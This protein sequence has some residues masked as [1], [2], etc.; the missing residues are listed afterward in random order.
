MRESDVLLRRANRVDE[1]RRGGE[2]L[3]KRLQVRR[4]VGRVL[5]A[6]SVLLI[7]AGL[8]S[9]LACVFEIFS[10]PLLV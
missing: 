10:H 8:P 5:L 9:N 7:F 4:I 1:T 6:A 3:L 2:R